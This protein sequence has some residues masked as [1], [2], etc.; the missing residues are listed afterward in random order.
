MFYG[1]IILA[2]L[3]AIYFLA[4]STVLYGLSIVIPEMIED[5]NWSRSEASL[6][7]SILVLALGLLGPVAAVVLRRIGARRMMGIGGLIAMA[8]AIGNFYLNSL[9]HYYLVILIMAVGIAMLGGVACTHTLANWFARKRG[10]ALGVF[11]STGGVGAFIAAP[12][13]SALVQSTGNWRHAWLVMACTTLLG[14]IIAVVFVRDDPA[15]KNTF[16]DGIDLALAL[17]NPEAAPPRRV[18]QTDV[19]WEVKEAIL[20]LPFWIT[21]FAAAAAVFGFLAVNTQGVLHLRALG[22]SPITAASAIGII[23]LLGAGGRLFGGF[24]G[25]RLDPR[26]LLSLGL[27]MELAAIIM[28]I[29]ADTVMM[30]YACAIILGAGNGAAIVASPALVANYYGGRNYAGMIAVHGLIVIV[31]GAS[32]PVV[33]SHVYEAV[34]SYTPVFL[35]FAIVSLIPV[36]ATL[37]MRPPQRKDALTVSLRPAQ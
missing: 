37:W 1:W 31:I 17:T 12:A 24:L 35:G 13:I 29:Y 18:Y 8:G 16:I 34:G 5:M 22:I 19:S 27:A 14:A 25:D 36:L 11:L 4:I 26:Y 6:G 23:G 32:G 21:V 33:A 3:S 15:D 2:A 9:W 30:T 28:L 7:F 10:L 20:T